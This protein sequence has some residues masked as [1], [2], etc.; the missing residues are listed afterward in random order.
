MHNNEQFSGSRYQEEFLQWTCPGHRAH[1]WPHSLNHYG[2]AAQDPWVKSEG[3][4]GKPLGSGST[5]SGEV[6]TLLEQVWRQG[7]LGPQHAAL[8]AQTAPQGSW[9]ERKSSGPVRSSVP[10]PLLRLDSV[11]RSQKAQPGRE[12]GRRDLAGSLGGQDIL[13]ENHE[14]LPLGL[15]C[16]RLHTAVPVPQSTCSGHQSAWESFGVSP[17]VRVPSC[18]YPP[19]SASLPLSCTELLKGPLRDLP[20]SSF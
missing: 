7:G 2:W 9:W 14:H 4:D 6:L 15:G 18:L 5:D 11:S 1:L 3:L 20:G 17:S 12:G 10:S 8:W 13:Q 19:E 16:P